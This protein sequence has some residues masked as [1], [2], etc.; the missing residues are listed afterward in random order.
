MGIGPFHHSWS[1]SPSRDWTKYSYAQPSIG[2]C[3]ISVSQHLKQS[4]ED[5]LAYL[6][7]SDRLVQ[8]GLVITN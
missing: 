3:A 8:S 6:L 2:V 7:Q 1:H 4:Y 5:V